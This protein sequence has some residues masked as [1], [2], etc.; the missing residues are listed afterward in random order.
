MTNDELPM[1]NTEGYPGKT[2]IPN[3]V[4]I[5]SGSFSV[6]VI[7]HLAAAKGRAKSSVVNAVSLCLV[8]PENRVYTGRSDRAERSMPLA[9]EYDG[10]QEVD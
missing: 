9:G 7:R 3:N 1:T 2:V 5:L 10:G 4:A 6:F 8:T